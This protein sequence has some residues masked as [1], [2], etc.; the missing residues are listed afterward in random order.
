[1]VALGRQAW[2]DELELVGVHQPFGVEPGDGGAGFVGDG[3]SCANDGFSEV[4]LD[5]VRIPAENLVG[6]E[7]DVSDGVPDGN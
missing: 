7:N 1:M 4:F 3:V 2:G 6:E 5:N